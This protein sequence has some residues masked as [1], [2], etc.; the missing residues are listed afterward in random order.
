MLEEDER[1]RAEEMLRR[2]EMRAAEECRLREDVK[3]VL[4]ELKKRGLKLAILT[5]NNKDAVERV[6]KRFNL[7]FDA[8][9]TRDDGDFKPSRKAV[10]RLLRDLRVSREEVIFIGDHEIDKICGEIAK[11]KTL[12]IGEDIKCL[13]ELIQVVENENYRPLSGERV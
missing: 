6:L 12:I 1:R 10:E 7:S 8:I 11:V 5:R 4:R 2:E 3:E 13:K 9:S